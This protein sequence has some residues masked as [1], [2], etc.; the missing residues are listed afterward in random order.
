MI[1]RP[2]RSTQSRSSAA[3]DVYK[4][5]LMIQRTKCDQVASAID[6]GASTSI[7]RR[8][9]DMVPFLF[10]GTATLSGY[11]P[12]AL[13]HGNVVPKFTTRAAGASA[14]GVVGPDYASP[15]KAPRIR[16][17]G[18]HRGLLRLTGAGRDPL[19]LARP[20][21][22]AQTVVMTMPASAR[23]CSSG[24]GAEASVISSCTELTS[25]MRAKARHPTLEP[26]ATTITWRARPMSTRLVCASISW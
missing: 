8:T 24:A 15:R 5:Q 22:R 7:W 20:D 14:G 18:L 3:S 23:R 16:G 26:S 12:A 2:P 4:R 6:G 19:G 17:I 11:L 25:Q 9:V 10:A 13:Q 1:R 21:G